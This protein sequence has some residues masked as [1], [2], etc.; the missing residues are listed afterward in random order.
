MFKHLFVF[1]ALRRTP[2][3]LSQ[4]LLATLSQYCSKI[5]TLEPPQGK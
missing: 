5:R 2:Q 4:L 1:G 3:S